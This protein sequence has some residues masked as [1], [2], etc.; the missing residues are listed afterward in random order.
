[1][2]KLF[3]FLK[4]VC[5]YYLKKR[6]YL[7]ADTN[8]VVQDTIQ[9]HIIPYIPLG[10]LINYIDIG[11]H[12]GYFVDELSK[13]YSFKKV[14][15]VEPIA[16]LAEML[17]TKYSS[18]GYIIYQ[19]IISDIQS[20]NNDFHVNEL[21]ETSSLFEFDYDMNELTNINTKL[22]RI[23]N[24]SSKTLDDIFMDCKLTNIDLLKIDVQ[25]AEHLVINGGKKTLEN[26]RYI[27]IE[28]SFKP[29]YKSSS[30]FGNIYS[31]L[32]KENFFL[33]EISEGHRGPRKELLQIDALF[34]NSKYNN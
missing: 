27:W 30:V 15:L 8:S 9:S 24:I 21:L 1:M 18:K 25:G 23:Q 33:L 14:I 5:N 20:E 17:K 34:A 12:K 22:A 2:L 4:K 19:N 29:L 16:Y 26:T 28:L 31:Q 32:K 7:I 6:N 10:Y 11:A 3:F 13:Y